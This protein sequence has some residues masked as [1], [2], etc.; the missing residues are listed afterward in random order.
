M[1]HPDMPAMNIQRAQK[2]LKYIQYYAG[3]NEGL[4]TSIQDVL[5][6]IRHL[7]DLE[8]L[9]FCDIER[10]ATVNYRSE[11]E[12]CMC[13]KRL[14]AK[15]NVE[16]TDNVCEECWKTLKPGQIIPSRFAQS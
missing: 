8:G 6:D 11:S 14:T 15:D 12:C 16:N 7:C 5:G 10:V 3:A 4:R 9:D 1:N 2:V 13:P